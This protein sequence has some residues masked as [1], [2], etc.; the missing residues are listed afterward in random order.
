M[1]SQRGATL[2][3]TRREP[4][5]IDYGILDEYNIHPFANSFPMIG[6][7]EMRALAADIKAH[8]QEEPIVTYGDQ[9]I[10]GRNR[11]VAC[12]LAG[13]TPTFKDWVPRPGESPITFIVSRNLHR[14]HLTPSQRAKLAVK[15]E[16][17][18]AEENRRLRAE[19]QQAKRAAA[20]PQ[21]SGRTTTGSASVKK[22]DRPAPTGRLALGRVREQAAKTMDVSTG[23][24]T[25]ARN[26]KNEYPEK[27]EQLSDAQNPLTIP[28]AQES[29]ITEALTA[30]GK[31][32]LDVSIGDPVLTDVKLRPGAIKSTLERLQTRQLKSET[33]QRPRVVIKKFGKV[34]SSRTSVRM[35]VSFGNPKV[36]E[37][38][39]NTLND[40][41]RVLELA[42][43][44]IEDE[45]TLSREKARLRK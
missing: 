36:A 6:D 34:S 15:M 12:N 23:Y 33:K 9:I 30:A 3:S 24:V 2:T 19:H 38:L 45:K 43:D 20:A 28:A 35:V 41:K 1:A 29:I 26:L 21:F 17:V 27:F 16:E 10:D 31:T 7:D 18:L 44:V 4:K 11:L 25:Q 39:L 22:T 37:E 32:P 42:Y 13:V 14:R 40:D 8:G 5:P